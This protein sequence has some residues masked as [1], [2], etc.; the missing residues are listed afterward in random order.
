MQGANWIRPDSLKRCWRVVV[1]QL[2]TLKAD[3]TVSAEDTYALA[4]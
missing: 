1:G 3:Q 4:A 2:A